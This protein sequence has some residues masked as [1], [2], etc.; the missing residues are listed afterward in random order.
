M[1]NSVR[2]KIKQGSAAGWEKHRVDARLSGF[3]AREI[4]CDVIWVGDGEGPETAE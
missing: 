2:K 3:D 4:L 1:H